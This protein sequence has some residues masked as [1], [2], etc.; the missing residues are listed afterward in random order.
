ML[1]VLAILGLVFVGVL[2]AI[3]IAAFW[4]WYQYTKRN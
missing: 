2:L 3:V 1:T 4:F